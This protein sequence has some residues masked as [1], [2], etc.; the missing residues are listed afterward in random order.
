MAASLDKAVPWT[1]SSVACGILSETMFPLSDSLSKI[2]LYGDEHHQFQR[3]VHIL[4]EGTLEASIQHLDTKART[5]LGRIEEAMKKP[6]DDENQEHLVDEHVDVLA[7]GK[8]G[9]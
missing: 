7:P 5:E 4:I 6:L 9:S 2:D 8:S 1:D 3:D